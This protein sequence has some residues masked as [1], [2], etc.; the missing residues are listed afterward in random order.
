MLCALI[1]N[2]F[3]SFNAILCFVR[4]FV[5]LPVKILNGTVNTSNVITQSWHGTR[6]H[7]LSLPALLH[8]FLQDGHT[9]NTQEK[10]KRT[11]AP[12][13]PKRPRSIRSC[14]F[15]R[16]KRYKHRLPTRPINIQPPMLPSQNPDSNPN[17]NL[18]INLGIKL[19][20]VGRVKNPS[21]VMADVDCLKWWT[22]C[23]TW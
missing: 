2:P 12:R 18:G 19:R 15:C 13:G 6:H 10:K 8:P 21:A 3:P 11:W 9:P 22:C 23:C 17:P 5:F 4:L 20:I 16:Y 7:P 14:S 1:K